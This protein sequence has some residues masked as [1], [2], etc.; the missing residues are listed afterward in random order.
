MSFICNLIN[1]HVGLLFLS[2]FFQITL[3][4]VSLF[5]LYLLCHNDHYMVRIVEFRCS[6]D[7]HFKGYISNLILNR[8]KIM[9]TF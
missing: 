1:A 5:S 3:R 8:G 7:F 9:N 6:Q 4:K 2:V